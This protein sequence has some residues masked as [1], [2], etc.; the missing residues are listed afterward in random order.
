MCWPVERVAPPASLSMRK[1]RVRLIA[2]RICTGAIVATPGFHVAA[3]A[4]LS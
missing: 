4:Q 2:R 3:G 1:L